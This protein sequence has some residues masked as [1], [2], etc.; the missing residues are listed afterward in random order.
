M[1]EARKSIQEE[2]AAFDWDAALQEYSTTDERERKRC[3]HCLSPNV[4]AKN[5]R[6]RHAENR[7]AGDYRCRNPECSEH[8]DSPVTGYTD[9]E[10]GRAGHKQGTCP[11]LERDEQGRFLPRGDGA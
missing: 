4:V 6:W 2:V 11:D 5:E 8:F 7:A 1:S 3:P 9:E 10:A